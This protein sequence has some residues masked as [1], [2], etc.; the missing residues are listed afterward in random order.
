MKTTSIIFKSIA[1]LFFFSLSS[2]VLGQTSEPTDWVKTK[3]KVKE[4]WYVEKGIPMKN[5]YW[6]DSEM[7]R[8]LGDFEGQ[9]FRK[10]AFLITGGISAGVGALLVGAW[11]DSR[12]TKTGNLGCDTVRNGWQDI[13]GVLG[14]TQLTVG[15]GLLIPGIQQKIKS[16]KTLVQIMERHKVLGL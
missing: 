10:K 7:N 6:T 2:F 12:C 16:D 15:A 11:L 3:V 5:Y 1:V 4:H 14:M 13:P 9:R 8:L